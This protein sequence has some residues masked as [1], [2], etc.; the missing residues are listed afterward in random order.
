MKKTISINIGGILF[1]IEED[2]FQKLKDYLESIAK[3][4]SSFEDSPE[5][6]EDIESR[7]AELFM[8]KLSDGR[9]TLT[10]DD[11][12]QLIATMGTTA[13]FEASMEAE[14]PGAASTSTSEGSKEQDS[15]EN[16]ETESK[17]LYR[18]TSRKILGGVASG[19]AFY[20]KIDPLWIRLAFVAL[21]VN[22][23]QIQLSGVAFLGYIVMWIA[24]PGNNNLPEN[25]KIKK[26]F[27]NGASRVLGGVCSGIAAYFAVDVA[28][29]RLL[30]VLSIFLGGS[31]ILVYIILWIITP[32]AKTLTEKMQMEGKPVTLQNIEKNVKNSLNVKEGEESPLLKILLFPF[33]L[34]SIVINGLAKGLGPVLRFL[35]DG[36]R[37]AFGA[38]LMFVGL[39]VLGG[40]FGVSFGT[41]SMSNLDSNFYLN[42]VDFPFHLIKQTLDPWMTVA[43]LLVALIP[44]IGLMLLGLSIIVNRSIT[45]SYVK[46]S[47]F[48]VWVLAIFLAASTIPKFIGG[49]SAEGV[50]THEQRFDTT[51]AT[52]VLRLKETGDDPLESVEIKLKG[53]EDSTFLAVIKTYS[54][55]ENSAEATEN[56][57]S[58]TYQLEKNGEDYIF[59]PKI[60]FDEQTKYRFQNVEVIFY[61][62]NNKVFRMEE[63]FAMKIENVVDSYGKD[64]ESQD[65][66]FTKNQ[67]LRCPTCSLNY[68]NKSD[69]EEGTSYNGGSYSY[70]GAEEMNFPFENFSEIEV[71][72]LIDVEI[73]KSTDESYSVVVRGDG[74]NL[75][76]VYLNQ[77]GNTLEVNFKDND[78]KWWS[79]K[80]I[81]RIQLI[82][83]MPELTTLSINGAS[84]GEVSGFEQDNMDVEVAGFSE[85]YMNVNAKRLNVDIAGASKVNLNGSGKQLNAEIAGAST[86]NGMGFTANQ[87]NIEA[88][89]ASTAR[90]QVE[91]NLNADASG[92]STIRYKGSPSVNKDASG[93]SSIE[94]D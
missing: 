64:I 30:F 39:S 74:D 58:I 87:A 37:I 94:R 60:S 59:D 49:F 34:I 50:H 44:T 31:G 75:D 55:G 6:I 92:M 41:Y 85:L 73:R 68:D 91:Q 3:Y 57:Q 32:E 53:H 36:I 21:L 84:K 8:A 27:R 67:G 47:L 40:L 24:V 69:E 52:P 45:N 54:R 70:A 1:H 72:A 28:I 93:M 82:I 35:V 51:P 15:S 25:Q 18:D 90:V 62:P 43:I 23:F 26:L 4:F 10:I 5:I 80:N 38:L 2:G 86:L 7:I 46:W 56:A 76:D 88:S 66:Y 71:G 17:K 13:D 22:A 33:R 63:A 11:V 79:K 12:T 83:N 14:E 42:G 77:V 29:V 20:L 9:Q 65:W 89:G 61:V 81:G 78:W 16:R 19:L 48:A